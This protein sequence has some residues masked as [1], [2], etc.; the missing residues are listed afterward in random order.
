MAVCRALYF[1]LCKMTMPSTNAT[2]FSMP[3]LSVG[4]TVERTLCLHP[5][6]LHARNRS[7]QMVDDV[8]QVPLPFR[9]SLEDEST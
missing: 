1:I 2:L 4:R 5:L 8:V 7:L 3:R 6:D 9:A